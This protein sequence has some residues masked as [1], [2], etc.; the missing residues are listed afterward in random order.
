MTSYQSFAEIYDTLMDDVPYDLWVRHCLALLNPPPESRIVDIGCGTGAFSLRLARLGFSVTAVDL[1]P[2]MI[3]V[4]LDKAR[5][6]GLK[7]Q[8][9]QQ[10]MEQLRLT[11]RVPSILCACDGVNYLRDLKALS[12]CFKSVY[13]SLLPG[14]RFCFDVSTGH[15]LKNMDGQLYGEER[16]DISYLWFNRYDDQSSSL[17]MDLSFFVR[18]ENGLFK[19]FTETHI[20]RAHTVD[21]LKEALLESGFSDIRF[22]S[23]M[24]MDAP[25][26][27]DQRI[28]ILAQ[29]QE[30]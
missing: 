21:E 19:R 27:T 5:R 2:Q 26:Q 13:D 3:R 7:V 4:L 28:H 8:A 1:S 14:G 12:R 10:N 29:K 6:Q 17:T 23:E 22:F 16:E 20:Q 24:T 30:K 25:T 15:K 11:K 18:Q 9:V